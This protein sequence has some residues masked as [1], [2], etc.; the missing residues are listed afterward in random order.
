MRDEATYVD[1]GVVESS[2]S[3]SLIVLEDVCYS[4]GEGNDAWQLGPLTM[5]LGK[6]PLTG[7]IGP[8]GS[9]KST[10]LRLVAGVI[11]QTRGQILIEGKD[12]RKYA[13]LSWAKEVGYLPQTPLMECAFSVEETVAFGRYPYTGAWGFL[14]PDDHAAVSEALQATDVA[15]LRHRR[16]NTL[17]GGE[18]Q[19]VMLASV[20]AQSPQ[21]LFLDEP[22]TALDIHHQIALFRLL[23]QWCDTGKSALIITHDL[24]LAAHYC[25]ELVLMH[26]GAVLAHGTPQDVLTDAHLHTAYNATIRVDTHP[27]TGTPLVLPM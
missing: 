13:L 7:I 8:N 26:N 10:L 17:S 20:F 22:T 14:T 5:T 3:S 18:R 25:T 9:G 11:R 12:I 15:H 24:T 23:T 16:I 19:R 6:A 2:A 4:Y 21:H 1:A 27:R